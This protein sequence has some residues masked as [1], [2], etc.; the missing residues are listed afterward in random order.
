MY[1]YA[2]GNYSLKRI[3]YGYVA[4]PLKR[5]DSYIWPSFVRYNVITDLKQKHGQITDEFE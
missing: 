4:S 5:S 2:I 3:I 1:S